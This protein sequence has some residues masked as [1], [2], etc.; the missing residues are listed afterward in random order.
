MKGL[1]TMRYGLKLLLCAILLFT[2][3]S[4][5]GCSNN[6]SPTPPQDENT[7][8]QSTETESDKKVLLDVP[9]ISQKPELKS[10]C[11]ITSLTMLL[12]Y[13]GIKVDKMTLAEKIKKDETPL[14]L[15]EKGKI[16][17][18][19]NPNDGFV[20]DI[21]GKNDGFAVYPK[22][23]L[24]LM[25]QYMPRRSE[26]LTKQPFE[27]LLKSVEE[28]RPVIV[29]VT[30]DFKPP[31][32]YEEWEKNGTKIKATLDEHAVL[33]VGYDK[34]NCYINNPHNGKKNQEINRD[35]FVDIWNIMGNMAISYEK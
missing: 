9:I 3:I 12:Q 30:I 29:W 33:L 16:K 23:M 2:N 5:T 10:G 22:P 24:E 35:T 7:Q 8:K 17:K 15:D 18:W 32:K 20:G 34:N 11:E 28:K 21:T 4:F 13:E 25:E 1:L 31:K 27:S 6:K 14:V 19:G 26:N